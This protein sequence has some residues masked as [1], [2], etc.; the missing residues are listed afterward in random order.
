MLSANETHAELKQAAIEAA[1]TLTG[2][3]ASDTLEDIAARLLSD[4]AAPLTAVEGSLHHPGSWSRGTVIYPQLGGLTPTRA[5]VMVVVAQQIGSPDGERLETRTLDVRVRREAGQ[6]RFDYLASAGGEPVPSPVSLPPEALA[7][8][9]NPR[10]ALPDSAR[11]DILAGRVS[12]FLLRVL[13]RTAERTPIS[14]VTFSS[15]HPWEVFGTDRQSDHSRGLAADIYSTG[16]VHVI[17]DHAVDSPTHALTVWLHGQ[18]EL[19]R[20]GSPW[21]MDD[22]GVISFT[23]ALHQDHIHIAVDPDL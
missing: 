8:L 6:W 4:G 23:D 17:D 22:L 20:I 3:E 11:W 13:A 12:P 7:V 15:G 10:I 21:E 1:L 18:P 19:A 16:G 5:S 2:Y 14:I 9:D